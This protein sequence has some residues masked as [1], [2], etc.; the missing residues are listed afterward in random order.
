MKVKMVSLDNIVAILVNKSE[1]FRDRNI[2]LSMFP[3]KDVP[4]IYARA[5]EGTREKRD[6]LI[7]GTYLLNGK[8]WDQIRELG[9]SY[10]HSSNE[11]EKEAGVY[12]L[13]ILAFRNQEKLKSLKSIPR[14]LSLLH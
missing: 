13:R 4:K 14:L 3:K 11:A 7:T 6:F 1:Y 12:F 10:F 9:V 5:A 8:L 2:D